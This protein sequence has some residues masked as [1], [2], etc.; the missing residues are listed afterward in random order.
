MLRNQILLIIFLGLQSHQQCGLSMKAQMPHPH[1]LNKCAERMVNL[2]L[3]STRNSL[4]TFPV[5][6]QA[7][8][9]RTTQMC[10]SLKVWRK[11]IASGIYKR[12]QVAVLTS[13]DFLALTEN[14]MECA[15]SLQYLFQPQHIAFASKSTKFIALR[16]F[17]SRSYYPLRLGEGVC[18]CV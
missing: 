3:F 17:S 5:P 2:N 8:Q 16:S 9:G 15:C 13:I 14:M 11:I 10:A 1:G 18:V 4:W 6:G 12:I 7:P